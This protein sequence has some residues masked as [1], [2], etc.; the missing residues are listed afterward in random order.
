MAAEEMGGAQSQI[1]RLEPL[2][3]PPHPPLPKETG[4]H[5]PRSQGR[6]L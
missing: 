5:S 3:Y 6:S 4:E 2:V 1:P